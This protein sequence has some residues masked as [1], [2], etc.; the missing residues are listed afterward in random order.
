M[1]VFQIP[2]NI[3]QKFLPF[4]LNPKATDTI[5]SFSDEK[6]TYKIKKGAKP[7]LF[8]FR[9]TGQY[10]GFAGVGKLNIC[11]SSMSAM[12]YDISLVQ[13]KITLQDLFNQMPGIQIREYLPD[14]KLDQCINFFH[15]MYDALKELL[16]DN[17]DANKGNNETTNISR[18]KAKEANRKASWDKFIKCMKHAFNYMTGA[19]DPN[20]YTDIKKEIMMPS[21]A[22]KRTNET[23]VANTQMTY[24]FD[25]PYFMYYS[26]QSC[27]TTNIY[28]IPCTVTDKKLYHSDGSKGWPGSGLD[29]GGIFSKVPLIGDKLN[30]IIGNIRISFMP[31]WDSK[32]GQAT[33]EPKIEIKFDLFND[34]MDAAIVNFIFVN[35]IVPGNKWLQ[36]NMFQHSPNLYDIKLEGYNRLFCCSATFNVNYK[37]VLRDP[38]D[39]FIHTLCSKHA[40]IFTQNG[41]EDEIRGH[42]L[43]KIPDVYEVTMTFNSLMP[44]NFNNYLYTFSENKQLYLDNSRMGY[45]PGAFAVINSGVKGF[46]KDMKKYIASMQERKMPL[47]DVDARNGMINDKIA[48]QAAERG[49]KSEKAKAAYE[50]AQKQR[51]F[52]SSRS[53]LNPADREILDE[54]IASTNATLDAAFSE[55]PQDAKDQMTDEQLN[56]MFD[57]AAT[58]SK[59]NGY[60]NDAEKARQIASFKQAHGIGS[61]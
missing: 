14:T 61:K 37:G 38:S 42:K 44:A 57:A 47:N 30:T 26:I 53:A 29:I 19:I 2:G 34:T 12:D 48:K 60:I 11:P 3:K 49:M 31:W 36:Y 21:D 43:I 10:K 13:N 54:K 56:G 52:E 18:R 6:A 9:S 23:S 51:I 45:I 16:S 50:N 59:S 15:D 22:Y 33:P 7:Q 1:S 41:I 35:T 55:L 28:E 17:E 58:A 39:S 32:A 27:T 8:T 20:L 25:F 5:N 40:T 4:Q 24:I 46:I